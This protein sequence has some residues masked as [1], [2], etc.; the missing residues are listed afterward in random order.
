[1]KHLPKRKAIVR[2]A[3]VRERS[4]EDIIRRAL[5]QLIAEWAADIAQHEKNAMLPQQARAQAR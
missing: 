5:H 2:A 4:I 3:R 1:M